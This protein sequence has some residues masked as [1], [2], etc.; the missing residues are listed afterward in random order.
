[1][2]HQIRRFGV[3]QTAKV[4]GALYALLGLVFVPIV[5]VVSMFAPKEQGMGPGLALAL[6]I[7]YGVFG[8][9]FAALGCAIYNVVAGLVGGVE[10]ELSQSQTA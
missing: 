2:P 6:P 9:I 5:L 10:V 3:M 8:F 7:L 1:M 4:V